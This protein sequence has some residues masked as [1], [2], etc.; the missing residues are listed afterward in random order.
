M[1]LVLIRIDDRMIHGQVVEGWARLLKIEHILLVNDAVSQNEM[2]KKLCCMAVPSSIKVSIKS[3]DAA[4]RM[5]KDHAF[6]K[7]KTLALFARP[8]DVL[9]FIKKGVPLKSVNV[10][11][12][13]YSE[14]KRQIL[15]YISVGPEDVNVFK[16]LASMGIEIEG[17]AV[18]T[19]ERIEVMRYL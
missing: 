14:G 18:P 10:G 4:A 17:R 2:Q 3:I 16:E 8:A 5:V 7:A 1:S 13:H 15:K 6:D 12:M 9:G 19:D 11:G